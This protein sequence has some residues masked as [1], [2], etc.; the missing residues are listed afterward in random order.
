VTSSIGGWVNSRL[1]KPCISLDSFN[2]QV[3]Y[4]VASKK[5]TCKIS[6]GDLADLLSAHQ[7]YFRQKSG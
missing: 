6:S 5:S 3:Q 7:R 1:P 2:F 4:E